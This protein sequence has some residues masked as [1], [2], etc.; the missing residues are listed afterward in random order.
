MKIWITKS[1]STS[2]VIGGMREVSVWFRKPVFQPS[3]LDIFNEGAPPIEMGLLWATG[4][5]TPGHITGYHIR[6]T[7]L[8]LHIWDLVEKSQIGK[9]PDWRDLVPGDTWHHHVW[10]AELETQWLPV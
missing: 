4:G 9:W 7:P 3:C 5:P 6:D 1:D 10:I 2:L 8:G